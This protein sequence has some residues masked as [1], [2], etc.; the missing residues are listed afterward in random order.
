MLHDEQKWITKYRYTK[1]NENKRT[2]GQ[3]RPETVFLPSKDHRLIY[4]DNLP[5]AHNLLKACLNTPPL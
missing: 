5:V 1:K 4:R 3:V 2:D